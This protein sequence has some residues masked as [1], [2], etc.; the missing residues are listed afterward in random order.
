MAPQGPDLKQ[1]NHEFV[2]K[3]VGTVVLNIVVWKPCAE[4]TNVWNKEQGNVTNFHQRFKQI[5]TTL[6]KDFA[7]EIARTQANLSRASL[8]N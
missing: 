7:P 8:E 1:V 2:W 6:R 4:S 5:T 3:A